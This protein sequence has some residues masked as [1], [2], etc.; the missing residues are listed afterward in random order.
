MPEMQ[1]DTRAPIFLVGAERSMT[2]L[3]RLM[4]D[5]HPQLAWH[6][7]FEFAVDFM[8]D[9]GCPDVAAYRGYYMVGADGEKWVTNVD[10][11]LYYVFAASYIPNNSVDPCDVGGE[12]FLY[13]FR[14]YC[15]EGFFD[16]GAGGVERA[17]SLGEGMP[18]DP[19][20]TVGTEGDTSHR[21]II[22]Q[23]GGGIISLEAPPGFQGSGMFYWR[24]LFE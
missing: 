2:T 7:E 18:T 17:I 22:N 4:L 10:V 9:E 24:E 15:G 13:V 19:R 21:V 5:H 20:I 14:I 12:S 8:P 16:D 11:F 23:Q 6:E 1:I 3:V